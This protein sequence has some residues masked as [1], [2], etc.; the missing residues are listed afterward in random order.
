VDAQGTPSQ[1]KLALKPNQPQLAQSI[2]GLQMTG[3]EFLQSLRIT[4]ANGDVTQ[5]EFTKSEAVDDLSSDER[6][7]L[8]AQ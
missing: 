7:L 2:K 8:G 5:I 3:G 4:L 1:W 6:T